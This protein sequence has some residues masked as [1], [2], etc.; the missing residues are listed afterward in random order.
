M[1]RLDSAGHPGFIARL[2]HTRKRF[3][4]LRERGSAAVSCEMVGERPKI[5]IMVVTYNHERYIVQ[6]LDSILMQQRDFSIEVNVID[7]ASTDRT[8]EIVR[9]YQERYP[10]V[11]QCFFNERNVGHVATQ[12]NTVRGFRTL[13]GEYFALLEGDD[14]W[15]DPRKLA[16]QIGYLDSHL[17][18]VACGHDTLKVYEDPDKEP[19]HFLPHKA[20]GR[21]RATIDDLIALAAVFH[22]SSV[23]YRNVFQDD[24]PLCL[25]DG[26][27]CEATINM[28]YGQF[29]YFYHM[30]GYMS[31]YRVHGAGLFS[32]RSQED[33]WLFHLFGFQRFGL[34]MG[35]RYIYQFSRAVCGFSAYVLTAQRRRVGPALSTRAKLLFLGHL[36]VAWPLF[37]VLR[38]LRWAARFAIHIYK[39]ACRAGSR[40]QTKM[41]S[42][43][44]TAIVQNSP[45]AFIR[46]GIYLERIVP[47]IG[48]VR[49]RWRQASRQASI[50]MTNPTDKARSQQEISYQIE[51]TASQDQ[52]SNRRQ[53]LEMFEKSPLTAG[54]RLFN[55]G[56]Y[57]RSSVLVKFIV[58]SQIYERIR[59]L[60]GCLVEF[61]TWWGQNLVLLENLRAIYEPFNKQRC[62]IGFDTFSGYTVRSGHD[63]ESDI[64]KEQSYATGTDYVEY[65]RELLT[66]HEGCN[67]LGHIRGRH[68]I[69][70]GDIEE[71]APHYFAQHA[72]LT[73]AFAYLDVALYRPTKAALQAIKPHLISGSILVLDEFTWSEAPGEAIAFKEVFDQNEVVLEKCVLY[74]SKTIVTIR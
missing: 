31:V 47:A 63:K 23:V 33:I 37:I 54:D 66:V 53:L 59:D 7:D 27:S 14:Y 25:A 32:T 40:F 44:Y 1:R 12:L 48:R 67:A 38:M 2:R 8:Q 42:L 45:V 50:S 64:W 61:G 49:L 29:G 55:I 43:S 18:C 74:P 41:L 72:E 4:A 22:L 26:Y 13:Q 24:P 3:G 20:F 36:I 5:S 69:I 34:Y 60:P 51:T 68:Q 52:L 57:V 65:L 46:A 17:E 15:T 6:A 71:T 39:C 58:M 73:V 30:P 9:S 56:M 35:W 28:V 21:A 62:I 70:P 11:V 16:K 10:G 19:E